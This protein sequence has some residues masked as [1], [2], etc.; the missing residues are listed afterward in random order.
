MVDTVTAATR[1][2]SLILAL[3]LLNNNGKIA[4]NIRV[5]AKSAPIGILPYFISYV[6]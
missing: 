1:S 6:R 3:L 2:V 5:R 4:R